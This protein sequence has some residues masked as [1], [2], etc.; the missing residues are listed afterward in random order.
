M[1]VRVYL[2]FLFL[3]YIFY[4]DSFLITIQMVSEA[5]VW[6]G[7]PRNGKSLLNDT[8]IFMEM[9]LVPL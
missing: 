4:S 8:N 5:I 9:G 7:M 1:Q 6:Y 2:H 3:F